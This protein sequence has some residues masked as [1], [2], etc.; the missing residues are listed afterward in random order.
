M[1]LRIMLLVVR[2]NVIKLGMAF[3]LLFRVSWCSFVVTKNALAY[4]IAA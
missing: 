4:F 3:L 2:L 1:T